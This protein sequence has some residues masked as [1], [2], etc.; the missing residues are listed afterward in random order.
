MEALKVEIL[1]ATEKH[2]LEVNKLNAEITTV[3]TEVKLIKGEVAES[4]T[5]CDHFRTEIEQSKVKEK[6]ISD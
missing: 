5:S 2:R 4:T 3:K 6:L 1:E